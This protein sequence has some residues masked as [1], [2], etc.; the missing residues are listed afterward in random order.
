MSFYASV[1]PLLCIVVLPPLLVLHLP[2]TERLESLSA[3][4]SAGG[5]EKRLRKLSCFNAWAHVNPAVGIGAR[6]LSGGWLYRQMS[7]VRLD[8]K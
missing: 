4:L 8:E 6:L 3:L 5:V 1:L 2:I 7:S